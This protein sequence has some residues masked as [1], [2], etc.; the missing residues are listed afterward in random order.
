[1]ALRGWENVTQAD[2]DRR[3]AA[4]NAG[5][6]VA[7]EKEKKSKYRN[8][9]FIIDGESFDSK[10]EGQYW[11]ELKL[12]EKAGLIVELKRQIAIPLLAPD[13][14]THGAYMPGTFTLV[15]ISEYIADF[16]Y[17]D[18]ATQQRHVVDAKGQR[19]RIA[20]YPLKKKW[21]EL[22]EGIVIEEV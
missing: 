9:R 7:T 3:Q 19:R 1:M 15:Q 17:R 16:V 11:I 22:Q 18:A 4:K 5:A 20:P 10:K 13:M 8:V 2:L 6:I 14:T 12:R 21:L